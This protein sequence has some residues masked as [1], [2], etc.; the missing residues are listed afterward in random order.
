MPRHGTLNDRQPPDPDPDPRV[1]NGDQASDVLDALSSATAR[2]ILLAL[3]DAPRPMSEV[4]EEVDTSVQNAKYH[5]DNLERADLV[6]VADT[7]Y[8]SK[9]AEMDVYAP[10]SGPLVLFAGES[11]G[12]GTTDIAGNEG[13]NAVPRP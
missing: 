8:S 5:L 9:G 10:A 12:G 1:L 4:A 6:E 11:D 7:W 3:Y 13:P 2:H